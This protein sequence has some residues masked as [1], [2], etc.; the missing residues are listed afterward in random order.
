MVVAFSPWKVFVVLQKPYIGP[1][2]CKEAASHFR[3]RVE[4]FETFFISKIYP[5]FDNLKP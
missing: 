5:D 2:D 4:L 1:Q 3:N